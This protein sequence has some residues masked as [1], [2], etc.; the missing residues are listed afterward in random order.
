MNVTTGSY[1][2]FLDLGFEPAEAQNLLIRADLMI[3]LESCIKAYGWDD[4]EAAA[5][6]GET[7]HC[8][9]LLMEGDIDHFSIDKLVGMVVKTGHRIKLQTIPLAIAA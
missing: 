8:I 6:F 5:F 9:R 4:E 2:V 3:N 7:P 1:N